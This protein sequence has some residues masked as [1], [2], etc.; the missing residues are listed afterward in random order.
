MDIYDQKFRDNIWESKDGDHRISE[1]TAFHVKNCIRLIKYN[2]GW[3]DEYLEPLEERL[4]YLAVGRW[5]TSP[6]K[7][8]ATK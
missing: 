2:P 4:K 3:R 7:R 5:T 6:F 8:K 1:M